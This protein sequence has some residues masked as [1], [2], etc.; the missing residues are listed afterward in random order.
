[1]NENNIPQYPKPLQRSLMTTLGRIS[2]E[3]VFYILR[4]FNLLKIYINEV[5]SPYNSS[6]S[7][8]RENINKIFYDDSYLVRGVFNTTLIWDKTQNGF[9][10]WSRLNLLTNIII[11]IRLSSFNKE[12]NHINLI[13]YTKDT[14]LDVLYN[15]RVIDYDTYCEL[16][17]KISYQ[18]FLNT[19][20]KY[21]QEFYL[22]LK[23]TDIKL[24]DGELTKILNEI[25]QEYLTI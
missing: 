25:C 7:P 4:R 2:Y 18:K 5:N 15:I 22:M 3:T 6:G 1:M 13:S 16:H 8:V 23:N 14:L 21:S 19:I 17:T 24:L 12:N 10:F 9:C 11:L 20:L